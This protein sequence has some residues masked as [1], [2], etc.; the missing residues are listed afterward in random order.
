M[1]PLNCPST[2][3]KATSQIMKRISQ[4]GLLLVLTVSNATATADEPLF[5]AKAITAEGAFTPGIEG[6]ATDAA[7]FLYV[8]NFQKQ[9]TI[10]RLFPDGSNAEVFATLPGQSVGNGLRFDR[11]GRLYV[12]D[13]TGH[14]VLRIDPISK[15]IEVFA[16]EPKMSQPNDLAISRSGLIYASDPNWND[17]T[18]RI[19]LVDKSGKVSLVADK[20]GTANG[21]EV[22]ADEKTLYV[23]ESVQRKIWAFDIQKDGTLANK[24]LLKEFPDHG[25]DGMRADV[26]GNLYVTRHGKGTVVKLSPQGEVL[27]EVDV[28][29]KMPTN[30]C[31]GGSDGKTVYVTEVEHRRVVA[32]RVDES[33]REWSLWKE[34]KP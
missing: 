19:W 28:L 23:N 33:G 5:K 6:P 9:Q 11:R 14:N 30:L 32:F 31:F 22:S 18:G 25:F 8:V 34:N 4:I 10:G 1:K 12:A 20:M 15:K 3:R 26:A 17:G 7:G 24:R 16:H 13:Y 21:V 27:Q 2:S 29:G